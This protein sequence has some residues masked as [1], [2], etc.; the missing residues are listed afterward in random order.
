MVSDLNLDSLENYILVKI[1]EFNF[2]GGETFESIFERLALNYSRKCKIDYQIGTLK[3]YY[4]DPS[5]SKYMIMIFY[6]PASYFDAHSKEE[7][8]LKSLMKAW[9]PDVKPS[10]SKFD[11]LARFNSISQ[12]SHY[13]LSIKYKTDMVSQLEEH[14]NF[15]NLFSAHFGLCMFIEKIDDGFQLYFG[16]EEDFKYFAKYALSE[17]E[18]KQFTE[19][20]HVG[21]EIDKI[22]ELIK[23]KK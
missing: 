15:I 10:S 22:F 12:D 11:F 4:E 3:E 16:R 20:Y 19:K 13:Y 6:D 23:L 7:R 21:G 2:Q 5:L 18:V 14:Y 9:L 1:T 8:V 17:E